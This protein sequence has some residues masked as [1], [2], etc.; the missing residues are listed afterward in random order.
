MKV[1]EQR[2]FWIAVGASVL[3]LIV[4]IALIRWTDNAPEF[5]VWSDYQIWIVGLYVG[6][7]AISKF[8]QKANDKIQTTI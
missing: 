2:K 6:G 5:K 4:F 8:S 1:F 7:N 3:G